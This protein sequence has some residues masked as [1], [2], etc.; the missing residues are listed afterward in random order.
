M[1]EPIKTLET[2]MREWREIHFDE[3]ACGYDHGTAQQAQDCADALQ[4]VR[5]ALWGL[6]DEMKGKVEKFKKLASTAAALHN[7]SEY[8]MWIAKVQSIED[9]RHRLAAILGEGGVSMA[10]KR[11]ARFK[12][13]QRVW[14]KICAKPVEI[15]RVLANGYETTCEPKACGGLGVREYELRPLTAREKGD[16][17]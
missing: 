14:C 9:D 16:R 7:L 15:L 8:G 17:G 2:V 6:H 1:S 10:S 11:K 5:D 12:V 4:P 3:D 13:G